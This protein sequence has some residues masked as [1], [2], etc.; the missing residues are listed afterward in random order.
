LVVFGSLMDLLGASRASTYLI[1]M[2]AIAVAAGVQL[3]WLVFAT[4]A[5]LWVPYR[6]ILE[7]I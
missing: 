4:H 7:L 3:V 1:R 5:D 2:L 6:S